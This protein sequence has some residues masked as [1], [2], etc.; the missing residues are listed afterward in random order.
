MAARVGAGTAQ[1]WDAPADTAGSDTFPEID[2]IRE[3]LGPCIAAAAEQRAGRLGLG[4]DRVLITAGT[5]TEDAYLSA[6]ARHVGSAFEPL[7]GTSRSACPI[8]STRLIEAAALGLLPLT[9]D[10][11]PC[12]V[13][14]PRGVAARR[15]VT[16]IKA[17]PTLA[18]RFRFTSAERLTRYLVRCCGHELTGQARNRLKLMWPFLSAAP[19]RWRTKRFGLAAA[20]LAVLAAGMA[21]PDATLF[22][23]EITLAVVFF[24]WLALR[25]IGVFMPR[26]QDTQPLAIADGNLPIYTIMAA[27]Y[28]EAA[29]VD[30]LLR[31]I[32]RLDYPGIR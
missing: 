17:D 24:A 20:A 13:V 3:I 30:G 21:A 27:L 5:I 9:V 7:D 11:Q 6:L 18:A 26:E 22:V 28:K 8:S 23:I 10:N 1:R 19:P 2:C 14:T 29:S 4:A 15:L 32:E 25:L 12:L 31:A 16:M